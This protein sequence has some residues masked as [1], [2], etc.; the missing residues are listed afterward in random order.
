MPT[1]DQMYNGI[2][3]A[4]DPSIPP[5]PPQVP[6]MGQPA[7]VPAQTPQQL[8]IQQMY[9]NIYGPATEAWAAAR[10]QPMGEAALIPQGPTPA[11][12]LGV[13]TDLGGMPSYGALAALFPSSRAQ[14]ET[15]STPAPTV[16]EYGIDKGDQERLLPNIFPMAPGSGVGQ[17]PATRSVPSVPFNVASATPPLPRARPSGSILSSLFATPTPIEQRPQSISAPISSASGPGPL[18]ISVNGAGSYRA[19]AVTGFPTPVEQRPAPRPTAPNPANYTAAQMEAVSRGQS[20]YTP[21]GGGA[22]MPTRAMNGQLRY[23]YG[24]SGSGGSLSG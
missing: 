14:T 13:T 5:I 22:M 9:E 20:S 7:A 17:P 24:D 8:S 19:P 12:G 16:A 2:Y 6:A 15:V 4:Y 1:L 18:R 10:G 3:S 23:T 21:A 11:P